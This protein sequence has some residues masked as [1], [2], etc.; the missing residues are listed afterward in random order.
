MA[1]KFNIFAI[2]LCVFAVFCTACNEAPKAGGMPPA[3]VAVAPVSLAPFRETTHYLG[4]LRSRKSITLSPNIEGHV[5]QIQVTAGQVVEAGQRIMQIDS[6]MQS[7][8]ADAG[9]DAADSV[10]SD[11]ATAKATL[12]SLQSTLKSRIANVEYTKSQHDRYANL[13][14]EGAV[15][16]SDLDSWKN[17]ASAA[18][19]E[20]D[21]TLQQIEAQ[22]M[23]IQ[24]YERSHKQALSN[25]RA[26]KEQ[27]KY[28]EIVAPFKGI[29]GDIPVKLGDHVTS[30]T[31][32]TTLTENHPLEVYISIPAEKASLMQKGMRV[33]LVATDGTDY[34]SS[35]LIFISPTVD[36]ASQTVLIKT[37]YPNNQSLLRAEQTVRAKI[38]WKTREGIS[39]PTSAVMQAAGK[40]FVFVA[41]KDGDKMSAKQVEIEVLG[42]EGD[43]YQVKSGLKPSD[44]IV[45]TGIQRL[46]DGAPIMEKPLSAK[47]ESTAHTTQGIH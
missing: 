27:L 6:R 7:A 5:T 20:R 3:V 23:T 19:A 30:E 45:T 26:Q 40:Y 32:L 35:E 22:K 44:R 4:N 31:A 11:L 1:S 12:R 38:V 8:Q 9:A 17:N 47:N 13:Q 15:S 37:L 14:S 33:E 16:H 25:W 29:V 28:Y 36:P 21:A 24:K 2:L 43:K 41:K 10:A 42:I 46:A 39:V 18:Q 34:G